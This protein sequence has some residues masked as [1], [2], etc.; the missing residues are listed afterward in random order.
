MSLLLKRLAAFASI[1]LMFIYGIIMTT[2][3][4][5]PAESVRPCFQ[6]LTYYRTNVQSIIEAYILFCFSYRSLV[7]EDLQAYL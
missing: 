7:L 6:L 1:A 4:P 5:V 3:Q 2:L